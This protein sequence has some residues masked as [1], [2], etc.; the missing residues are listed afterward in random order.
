MLFQ[1]RLRGFSERLIQGVFE[2]FI[3]PEGK[4]ILQPRASLNI[5][6]VFE[7]INRLIDQIVVP[8]N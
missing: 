6:V 3:L 4:D 7:T 8:S 2:G 5:L 1:A